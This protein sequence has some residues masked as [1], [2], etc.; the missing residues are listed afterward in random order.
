MV[1]QEVW[2]SHLLFHRVKPTRPGFWKRVCIRNIWFDVQH[3]GAVNEIKAG[4]N[5]D[6]VFTIDARHSQGREHDTVGPMWGSCCEDPQLRSRPSRRSNQGIPTL[7]EMCVRDYPYVIEPV[8][9]P[10]REGMSRRRVEV[11]LSL[12][13]A[14]TQGI[15]P[16]CGLTRSPESFLISR[17]PSRCKQYVAFALLGE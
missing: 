17:G 10:E 12:L 7:V 2:S 1:C 14:I 5:N 3:R 6:A 16:N 11:N 9:A 13:R 8:Q 15:L 4:N